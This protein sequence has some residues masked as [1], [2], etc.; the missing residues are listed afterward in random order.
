MAGT[1]SLHKHV[2]QI[3][4]GQW[5][6]CCE[7]GQLKGWQPHFQAT[8]AK[9][10]ISTSVCWFAAVSYH[11]CNKSWTPQLRDQTLC[12][13][14]WDRFFFAAAM[15]GQEWCNHNAGLL[16]CT[17]A[18]SNLKLLVGSGCLEIPKGMAGTDYLH[19]HVK[20]ISFGQ[21][22]TS[23][24]HGQ[25]KGWQ[26][27]FQ[28]TVAKSS[29]STSVRWFAAVSYHHCHKSWTPQLRDQPLCFSA[30]DPFFFAAAMKGQEWC[31]HNAGLLECTAA[32]SNL[33]L[34]VGSG[35]LEI[36]KGM[37]GTD[38]LHKHVKQI[39]FGQWVTCCEHGQLK[40]WQPHFQPTVAKSSISTSVCWFAAVSYHHCNKSWTPQLRDQTLCFFAWDWVFSAA[41]MKG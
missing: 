13:F 16:E 27:H 29:I 8:V 20:Q 3:S 6:T 18:L 17:A 30:W 15:K 38:S 21:W 28:P 39:S 22:V 26:P 37:A 2:K 23:F 41:A 7:D 24:E 31:N 9:S 33:K 4:F 14:G 32:L 35:C 36:P 19:K 1:D 40:G 25:L 34:L 12:F 11:H 5:V 10:S